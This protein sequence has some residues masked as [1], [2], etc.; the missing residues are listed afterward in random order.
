M[1]AAFRQQYLSALGKGGFVFSNV[2]TIVVQCLGD[3]EA[4]KSSRKETHVPQRSWQTE[5]EEYRRTTN[6]LRYYRSEPMS[7]SDWLYCPLG[8]KIEHFLGSNT[9]HENGEWWIT[10]ERMRQFRELVDERS[11]FMVSLSTPQQVSWTLL[12]EWRLARYQEPKLSEAAMTAL[13]AAASSSTPPRSFQ[14]KFDPEP[15]RSSLSE[16]SVYHATMFRLLALEFNPTCWE[17]YVKDVCMATLKKARKLGL[18]YASAQRLGYACYTALIGATVPKH[19]S[20]IGSNQDPCPWLPQRSCSDEM[21]HYLWDVE[22]MHTIVAGDLHSK[23]EYCCVSHTWGRWRKEPPIHVDGVPWLVP[24]NDRFVV[25]NLPHLLRSIQPHPKYTWL[26]LFCIPQDGSPKANEEINRQAA[27]FQNAS[28]CLAWQNDILDWSMTRN[29]LIWLGLS[30]LH[31]TSVPG[32]YRTEDLLPNAYDEAE[33]CG[34]LFPQLSDDD[35]TQAIPANDTSGRGIGKA[36]EEPA[37]W[38]SS[39]WTLQEAMLC[40]DMS[41]VDRYWTQLTDPS[42][43]PVPFNTFFL[44]IDTIN[45]HWN[46]GR[47]YKTHEG[48]ITHYDV[49]LR[50]LSDYDDKLHLNWPR[51]ARQFVLLADLTRM[52]YLFGTSSPTTLLF[53]ANLRQSTS[54]RAPAI[55]SALGITDWYSKAEMDDKRLVLGCYPLA[56]VREAASKLGASFYTSISRRQKI[57]RASGISDSGREHYGSMMPFSAT[58]GWLS[59][60]IGVPAHIPHEVEDHPAVSSW[61]INSDGSVTVGLAGIVA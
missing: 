27:I 28:R 10:L 8:A 37:T 32:L 48:Q 49:H 24:Q 17:P 58:T 21:P 46:K 60:I 51:A 29:A 38:F 4:I 25:E 56:F 45:D 9:G 43:L 30:F 12:E 50:S 41:L 35:L 54:S 59:R 1:A 39:L 19:T 20:F 44:I 57:P 55:M 36:F 11:S 40:P 53:A 23:P 31:T 33:G 22:G 2:G 7:H 26:D 34:E 61:R 6:D 13:E 47:A 52:D 18:A 5:Y 15:H 3:Y 16:K 14:G 42:G